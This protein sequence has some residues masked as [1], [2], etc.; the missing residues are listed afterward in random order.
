MTSSQP[1]GSN[2]AT[3][4]VAALR[5]WSRDEPGASSACSSL[6]CQRPSCFPKAGAHSPPPRLPVGSDGRTIAQAAGKV[7]DPWPRQWCHARNGASNHTIPAEYKRARY[8]AAPVPCGTT[9][10]PP[11]AGGSTERDGS[12]EWS[13]SRAEGAPRPGGGLSRW[14]SFPLRLG[15]DYLSGRTNPRSGRSQRTAR[16]GSNR[17]L[18]IA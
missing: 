8:H 7:A 1:F 11:N 10:P 13:T 6:T 15:R 9:G 14:R 17:T 2:G 16:K 4:L 12:R 3:V 5:R 18:Q